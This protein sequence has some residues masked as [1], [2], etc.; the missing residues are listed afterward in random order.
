MTLHHYWL[1]TP[2]TLQSL[3]LITLPPKQ[4]TCI[5]KP[6]HSQTIISNHIF[7][8]IFS[9]YSH[10]IPRWA[11]WQS[12]LLDKTSSNYYYNKKTETNKTKKFGKNL[13]SLKIKLINNI[14]RRQSLELYMRIFI[15]LF[16]VSVVTYHYSKCL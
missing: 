12:G 8:S 10:H 3:H 7:H 14:S 1:Y 13:L 2:H 15:C 11:I 4:K 6:S 16:C 9:L 5:S